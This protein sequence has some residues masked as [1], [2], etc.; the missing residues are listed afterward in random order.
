MRGEDTLRAL[1]AALVRARA[2]GCSVSVA[3]VDAG[4]RTVGALSMESALPS[5]PDVAG[6]KAFSACRFGRPTE[7]VAALVTPESRQIAEVAADPRITF[8]P[9]G[10]PILRD[11]RVVGAIGVA[12]GTSEQDADCGRAAKAAVEP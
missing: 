4:G 7:E 8:V 10:L 3:V 5:S 6:R 12:G 11:G 2:L 1:E 9:G